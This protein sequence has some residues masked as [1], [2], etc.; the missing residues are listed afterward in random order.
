LDPGRAEVRVRS[1]IAVRAVTAVDSAAALRIGTI[2]DDRLST[3]IAGFGSGALGG[4]SAAAVT[5][6]RPAIERHRRQDR[7]TRK[8][9]I[10]WSGFAA[11]QQLLDEL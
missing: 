5:D 3:G 4:G 9:Y 2:L 7:R 1:R 8:E 11:L 6:S 10:R